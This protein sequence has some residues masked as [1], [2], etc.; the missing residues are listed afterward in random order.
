MY[1]NHHLGPIGLKKFVQAAGELAGNPHEPRKTRSQTSR[2]LFASNSTL[3]EHYYMLIGFGPQ[4][5]LH[6]CN[7]PIWKSAM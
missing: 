5:Y 1:K 6:Y 7:D 4:I 3:A 2:D